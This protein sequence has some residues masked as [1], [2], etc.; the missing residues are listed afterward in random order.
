MRPILEAKNIHKSYKSPSPI[1]ILSGINLTL[2]PESATAIM[3]R[4]G[5]GKSTLLH[6][7]GTLE[8]FDS[9]SL[10][11]A[12]STVNSFNTANIRNSQIG[13]VF[14]SYQ[15]LDDFTV[16][17]NVLFPALI[18]R[19]ETPEVQERALFLLEQVGL[20]ERAHFPTKLLSGGE[21]QR[22]A[23]ARALCNDPPL[24]LAD[25]PSG[26]LDE[27]NAKAIFQLLLGLVRR[28]KKTLLIVTHDE[29]FAKECDKVFHLQ[30][31]MLQ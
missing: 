15:L 5:A 30:N 7:L 3:G 21:K 18:S 26:N 28:Q 16:L 12:G 11:I 17:E 9:G 14:Q 10:V 6:I 22:A 19:K 1:S 27:G 20:K 25:E 8:T 4:S 2:L 23:I 24:L 13:F 31:G 29:A